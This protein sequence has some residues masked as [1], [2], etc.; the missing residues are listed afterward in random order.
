MRII[1][2]SLNNS[3]LFT[4]I[5]S[6]NYPNTFNSSRLHCSWD[7]SAL[8]GANV[9][10]TVIE[11]AVNEGCL[12]NTL[13][14]LDD[15]PE[16]R[17]STLKYPGLTAKCGQSSLPR[18]GQSVVSE[19]V[20][21]I[22]FDSVNNNHGSVLFKIILEATEPEYCPA[23]TIDDNCPYGPCCEGDDCCIY[24]VGTIPKGK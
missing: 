17:N 9:K 2:L 23:N 19:G 21:S 14:I 8:H 5:T 15:T 13:T 3:S 16:N 18:S 11:A 6:P 12:D 7:I 22:K 20:V 4:E 24:H 10:V 1:N